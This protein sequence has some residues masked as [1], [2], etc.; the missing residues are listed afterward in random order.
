ME[1][2]RRRHVRSFRSRLFRQEKVEE[3]TGHAAWDLKACCDRNQHADSSGFPGR[4]GD[5]SVGSLAACRRRSLGG[6]SAPGCFWARSALRC[7]K[8]QRRLH[9]ETRRAFSLCRTCHLRPK[10]RP[11]NIETETPPVAL[12]KP[13]NTGRRR[14]TNFPLGLEKNPIPELLPTG[15]QGAGPK[16]PHRGMP[17]SALIERLWDRCR[18]Q[19]VLAR[20]PTVKFAS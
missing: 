4:M 2:S 17:R 9:R 15:C 1:P 10:R 20:S 18:Q 8:L 14:S 3:G 6:G 13:R 7:Y 12:G 16:P 19:H 5:H 11:H